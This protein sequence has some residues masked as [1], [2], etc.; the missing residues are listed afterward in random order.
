MVGGHN[1]A[2][3]FGPILEDLSVGGA[4]TICTAAT[5][6]RLIAGSSVGGPLGN[7]LI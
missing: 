7:A 2:D 1:T 6:F 3:A 4:T 5:A